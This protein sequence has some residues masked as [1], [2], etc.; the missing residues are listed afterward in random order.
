[1]NNALD[2]LK[3]AVAKHQGTLGVSL[4]DV[5]SGATIAAHQAGTPLNPASNM[6]IL[7]AW[8]ALEMLGSQHTYR[9]ALYGR[10]RDGRVD[11]LVVRGDGDPSL[12]ARHLW[13]MVARIKRAGVTELGDVLVDQSYFDS[14]N[15]PPAFDQQPDEWASFRAP[16]AAASLAQ[17]TVMFEVRAGREAERAR[18]SALP[19]SFI[20]LT[21]S[22]TTSGRDDPEA[23]RLTLEPDGV[24][25]NATIGGSVPEGSTTM[26]I[27]RRVDDPTLLVGHAVRDIAQQIG[28]EVSGDVREGGRDARRLLSAH[29]SAPLGTLLHAAGKHSNNFYA[30]M[31]FK[32]LSVAKDKA[33]A[34]FGRSAARLYELLQEHGVDL[35]GE[36]ISN[37]SG[38]FDANRIEPQTLTATLVTAHRDPEVASELLS[39]LAIGGVDGTLRNRF[40]KWRARRAVRA[41]TGTLKAV[42]ALSGYILAPDGRP[43]LAFSVVVNGAAGKSAKLRKDMDRFVSDVATQ[44]WDIDKP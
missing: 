31:I 21:G 6:K 9:T 1:V 43:P 25:L 41:K 13:E 7:T 42:S 36:R 8:A 14:E 39:V 4:V 12:E 5:A 18:V 29:R 24:R 2:T 23:V 37:G 35:D 10:V 16:V 11:P 44:L 19:T 26:R 28:I 20:S 22:V 17:N 33:P 15:T 3:A 27:W 34:T 32:S 38:L 30:E 40:G